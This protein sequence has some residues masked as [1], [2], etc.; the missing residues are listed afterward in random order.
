[1]ALSVPA[2]DP[3]GDEPAVPSDELVVPGREF[4]V[5]NLFRDFQACGTNSSCIKVNP[6]D[7]AANRG[8]ETNPDVCFFRV[9]SNFGRKRTVKSRIL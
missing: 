3:V 2:I 9:D 6:N 7:P 4:N 5:L 8:T 1:M